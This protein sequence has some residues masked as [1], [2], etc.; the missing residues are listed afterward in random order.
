[1]KTVIINARE[2]ERRLAVLNDGRIEKIM[3]DQP[4]SRSK[5][6]HIYVGVVEKVVPS[7]NA[8]F[9]HLGNGMKGYIHR[10][11][12]V[13]YIS[14]KDPMKQTTP[15]SSF[16]FQGEKLMV[17]IEKDETDHKLYRLT[18]IIELPGKNIVYMP[19]GHYI[20]VSKKMEEHTREDWRMWVAQQK[21]EHEGILIRTNA[22]FS[23]KE[24]VFSEWKILRERYEKL[25]LFSQQVKAP[26]LLE[27]MDNFIQQIVNE[28]IEL[29]T[30]VICDSIEFIQELK[31]H[32]PN[33]NIQFYREKEN[34]FTAYRID[35]ELEKATKKVYWLSNGSYFIMEHTEACT[36]ID[37]NS[38]KSISQK[39]KER[40][41]YE[42]N[43]LAAKEIARQL[44]VQNISGMILIDF[45]N[46]KSQGLRDELVKQF[47]E[48]LKR[49][50]VT[51]D[52]KGFTSLGIL[53]MTRK[54]EKSSLK[55]TLLTDCPVCSGTGKIYSAVSKAF[56][57][58]RELWEF[59]GS[60][61]S[62]VTIEAT[63]DVIEHF[64]GENKKFKEN[65]E[66]VLNV[67]IIFKEVDENIPFYQ[68]IKME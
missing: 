15:I 62:K 64:E 19:N 36:V 34:I 24:K 39:E 60:D 33:I 16:V 42:T 17:Q 63:N 9:V 61:Y 18:G 13:S 6:G 2:T 58:E 40:S 11:Q 53:E 5:V 48:Y 41:I 14:S 37:V 1:M 22:K 59:K 50:S 32:I 66:E 57:L 10:N 25:V 8:A 4:H 45:I 20:A 55:E 38:G 35:G 52:I 21:K 43:A 56:Q 23:T 3:I 7:L 31:T 27:E 54:R 51:T 46:M 65:L 30:E 47:K 12:L 28:T 44:M 67:K 68:V 26:A 49:D 29:E